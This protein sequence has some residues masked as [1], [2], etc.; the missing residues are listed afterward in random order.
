MEPEDINAKLT[1]Q[2]LYRPTTIEEL[3]RGKILCLL[4]F[5]SVIFFLLCNKHTAPALVMVFK[6]LGRNF[7]LASEDYRGSTHKGT[8]LNSQSRSPCCLF[9]A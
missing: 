4:F 7:T 5:L 2:V 9:K 3:E 6:Y 8:K 1:L